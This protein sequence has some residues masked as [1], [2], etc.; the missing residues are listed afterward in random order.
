M[1][2]CPDAVNC[3]IGSRRF[4]RTVPSAAF[5]PFRFSS[6]ILTMVTLMAICI[7]VIVLGFAVLCCLGSLYDARSSFYYPK[8]KKGVPIPRRN[9]SFGHLLLLGNVSKEQ[10]SP[11]N[12]TM[13]DNHLIFSRRVRLP[14]PCQILC[15]GWKTFSTPLYIAN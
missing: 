15:S 1:F 8:I 2:I 9:V 7:V 11:F 14:L 5:I 4:M 10:N 6:S 12:L 3:K 13:A